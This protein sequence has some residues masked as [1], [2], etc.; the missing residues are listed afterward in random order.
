MTWE[1][2]GSASRIDRIYISHDFPFKMNYLSINRTVRS[3]HK[4]VIAQLEYKN[5]KNEPILTL[6]N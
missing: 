5:M 6:G 4:A 2:N 3:D 1:N